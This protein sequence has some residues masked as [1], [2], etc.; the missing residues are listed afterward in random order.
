[1]PKCVC[2]F[3]NLQKTGL[4]EFPEKRAPTKVKYLLP[5][6]ICQIIQNFAKGNTKF[7]FSFVFCAHVDIKKYKKNT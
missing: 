3:K 1:M 7:N 2:I 4:V 6:P 5:V